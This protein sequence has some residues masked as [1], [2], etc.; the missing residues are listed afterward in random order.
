MT[1]RT[2]CVATGR[3]LTDEVKQ[4]ACLSTLSTPFDLGAQNSEPGARWS[5]LTLP[6]HSPL[7]FVL[8]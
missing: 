7:P 8:P 6:R 1:R 5:V 4:G 2:L 3:I